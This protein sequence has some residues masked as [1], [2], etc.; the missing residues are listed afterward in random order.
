M[1]CLHVPA[2]LAQDEV[3]FRLCHWLA[4]RTDGVF[5]A[6]DSGFHAADGVLLVAEAT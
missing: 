2:A 3:G 5:Q 4:Q 1:F 6:D